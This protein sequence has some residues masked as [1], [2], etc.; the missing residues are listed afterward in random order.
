MHYAIRH[1]SL[2]SIINAQY[3][4]GNVY[5]LKREKNEG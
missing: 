4:D 1:N 2:L 5:L 3:L